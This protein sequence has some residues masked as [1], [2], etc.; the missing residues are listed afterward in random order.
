MLTATAGRIT[1]EH[2]VIRLTLMACY[3]AEWI[4]ADK[5]KATANSKQMIDA[6]T[7]WYHLQNDLRVLPDDQDV[8]RLKINWDWFSSGRI[9]IMASG[10]WAMSMY[11]NSKF[12]WDL[13]VLP[14]ATRR[15]TTAT[16]D[17]LA[18]AGQS[19][20]KKAAWEFVKWIGT[21]KTGSV[22][23]G[24]AMSGI[25]TLKSNVARYIER[26]QKDYPK[27]NMEVLRDSLDYSDIESYNLY[28]KSKQ[29][30]DAIGEGMGMVDKGTKSLKAALDIIQDKLTKLLNT[31]K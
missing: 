31:S 18:I 5:D 23:L 20:N 8:S 6:W 25:P 14:M 22:L 16:V 17:G 12:K 15:A 2:P 9:G 26:Q 30:S 21:D 4:D 3:G 1:L 10:S 28:A 11:T 7:Y 19:K 27:V 29:M 24:D 13:G